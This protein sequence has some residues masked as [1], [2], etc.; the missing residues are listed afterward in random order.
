[1]IPRNHHTIQ[2]QKEGSET[3]EQPAVLVL[4][5]CGL[6]DAEYR[7]PRG[8]IAQ[9]EGGLSDGLNNRGRGGGNSSIF[10]EFSP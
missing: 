4:A 10:L 6:A 8:G 5:A 3:N 2:G 9:V 1:M 7:Q